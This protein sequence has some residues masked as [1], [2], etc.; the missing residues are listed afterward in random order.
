MRLAFLM[1]PPERVFPLRD[2]TL[3]FMREAERRGHEVLHT[4]AE[5]LWVDQGRPRARLHRALAL[6]PPTAPAG[7]AAFTLSEPPSDEPLDALDALFVRT[8]PPFDAAYLHATQILSLCAARPFVINDPRGLRDANEKLYALR[9][10][11]LLPPTIVTAERARLA[12][13]ARRA[14]RGIVVKPLDGHGG[15]GVLWVRPGDPN[16]PSI[17]DALTR[18]GHDAVLAQ[19]Y[20][21]Q[22]AEGDRRLL[23]L[24]GEPLAAL[25]RIA[26]PGDLRAN[27]HVG[28]R[29]ERAEIDDRDRAIA[30]A[31]KERLRRDGLW[32]VGVDV[33]GG[34]VTEVNVTSPTGVADV[35]RLTGANVSARVLDFV[36][37]RVQSVSR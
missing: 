33:I 35:E 17:L 36:D 25:N 12:E 15:L 16:A 9:F 22:V 1:D 11:D 18:E 5:W 28:A 19:E 7:A 26:P 13:F 21:E 2:T 34:R 6:A 37:R 24:D 23:L 8:D 32:F 27:L 3:A 31:M 14:P 29:P 20:L 30:A 4:R 10:P